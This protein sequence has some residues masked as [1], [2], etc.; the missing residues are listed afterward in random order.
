MSATVTVSISSM[1]LASF[2]PKIPIPYLVIL[3]LATYLIFGVIISLLLFLAF[4]KPEESQ[5]G[6]GGWFS[7]PSI[8]NYLFFYYAK[9]G[10]DEYVGICYHWIDVKKL[11]KSQVMKDIDN[12]M[13]RMVI[14]VEDDAFGDI[15]QTASMKMSTA[16]N[17]GKRGNKK[18]LREAMNLAKS[19][20]SHHV[21]LEAAALLGTEDA[22]EE[23]LE[24]FFAH[25]QFYDA[26]EIMPKCSVATLL[27][28]S[29]EMA[30]N[31]RDEMLY[32]TALR[33][34]DRDDGDH[35]GLDNEVTR[36]L[37]ISPQLISR[38]GMAFIVDVL[39]CIQNG[40][41]DEFAELCAKRDRIR[42]LPD[43]EITTLLKAKPQGGAHVDLS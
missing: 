13:K 34:L 2:P 20:A 17:K 12:S 38:Q 33:L 28:H 22:Y 11:A 41:D 3:L 5:L 24:Y 40:D 15:P 35:V 21:V 39:Y 25:D 10:D 42:K 8:M 43:W 31:E 6:G 1:L 19:L 27:N 26:V 14:G 7:S 9:Y 30:R 37:Q 29:D 16:L 4:S 18:A 32:H 36:W 23:A